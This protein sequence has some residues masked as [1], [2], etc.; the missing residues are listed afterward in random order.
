MKKIIVG[1]VLGII[2]T[3]AVGFAGFTYKKSVIETWNGI[4]NPG[5]RIIIVDAKCTKVTVLPAASK[6]VDLKMDSNETLKV[7]MVIQK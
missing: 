7:N 2:F 5:E 3:S 6:I 4:V 1:F